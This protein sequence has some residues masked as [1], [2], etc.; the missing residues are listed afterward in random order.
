MINSSEGV[1][2]WHH[3]MFKSDECTLYSV[4]VEVLIVVSVVD[5]CVWQK[6]NMFKKKSF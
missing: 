6:I 5:S 2:M 1:E 3:I 4:N